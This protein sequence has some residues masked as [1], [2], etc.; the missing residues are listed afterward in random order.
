MTPKLLVIFIILWIGFNV[1]AV[2]ALPDPKNNRSQ[3]FAITVSAQ[4]KAG[5]AQ[6]SQWQQVG[7]GTMQWL[8]WT[9]YQARLLTPDG[10]YMPGRYPLALSL[11]YQRAIKADDLVRATVEQ[12]QQ[13]GFA[14][15]NIAIWQ[16]QL[17]GLWPD[18]REG[19]RL[20]FVAMN[21]D[22][23]A[24]FYNGQLLQKLNT[25]EFAAAF[26][27]IWLAPESREPRLRQALMGR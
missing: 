15:K 14:D 19:D 3:Q 6:W 20:T 11:Q 8:W 12:W 7:H 1:S 23:G 18:V 17:Q 13:L 22:V 25:P 26:V 4:A 5:I 2:Q 16:Q 9:L 21:T 24:F 10:Q 27:A